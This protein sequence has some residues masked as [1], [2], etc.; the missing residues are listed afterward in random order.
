MRGLSS[1]LLAAVVGVGGLG[2][3][4][5]AVAPPAAADDPDCMT[6]PKDETGTEIEPGAP[7]IS[8]LEIGRAQNLVDD[9]AP[10]RPGPP[11]RVAVLDSG[12]TGDRIPVVDRYT[13]I[14]GR[15]QVMF[16]HGTVVAGLIAGERHDG[17]AVG[18]APDAEIVDVRVYDDVDEEEG[19]ELV[20]PESLAAG[21]QWVAREARR[22]NIRV[23][24]VSVAVEADPQLKRAVQAVRRAG[25]VVVAAAGNRPDEGQPFDSLFGDDAPEPGEDAAGHLFPTGYD[26]VV[27]VSATGDGS[28]EADA[29]AYVLRNSNTTVAAP[30]YWG[31]SYAVNGEPCRIDTIA[32]SWAT[33][34]VSGVLALLFQMFPD[35]T[36]EQVV[37]RLVTT[38]NGTPDDPNPVTGAGVV[39]PMEALTRPLAP[40]RSGE[41]DRTVSVDRDG[42]PAVAPDPETDPLAGPREDAV[43]WGLI[44]GGVLVV[45]LLLRPVLARRR[46]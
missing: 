2:V 45:A 8:Q 20:S 31:V 27:S 28:P 25:V 33:A 24:N 39:Q 3:L 41:M 38:A 1:A 17:T 14:T 12:V 18:V 6:Q 22:L 23:A 26:D 46:S 7:V 9:E 16:P 4:G 21:L 43:W 35:D 30:T 34:E 5:V 29:S 15:S 36:D 37:A 19:G 13:G 42:A 10:P 40:A 11:V 32:T 44:G